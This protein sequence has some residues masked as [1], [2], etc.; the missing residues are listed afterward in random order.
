MEGCM[1]EIAVG[2]V[3]G[4]EKFDFMVAFFERPNG[5]PREV[6]FK[7][8][9]ERGPTFTIRVVLEE[10]RAHSSNDSFQFTAVVPNI[11]PLGE[12]RHLIDALDQADQ[13]RGFFDTKMRTG[14]I[15]QRKEVKLP[16]Y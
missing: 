6:E 2:I 1:T 9:P 7:L 11:H 5:V 4:P 12:R 8:R 3:N 15:Y 13:V 16:S 10:V 14:G